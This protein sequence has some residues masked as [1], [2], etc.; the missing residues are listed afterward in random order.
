[1]MPLQLNDLSPTRF[2]DLLRQRCGANG[3]E[4]GKLFAAVHGPKARQHLAEMADVAAVRRTVLDQ[5]LATGEWPRLKKV[6]TETSPFDGFTRYLFEC[7]DGARIEAVR[8]P[9]PCLARGAPIPERLAKKPHYIVCLSS[10]VGCALGCTFCAT[11]RMGFQRNL[12]V[13]EMVEQ[14]R[15]IREEAD[16]PVRGA[17]FMGMGEPLLN[18]D[19]VMEVA[20]ILSAPAGYALSADRITI[21]T[22]GVVPAIRR[23]TAER[24]PY[25]LAIS[26]TAATTAKR[27]QVMPIEKVWPLP[28]LMA[29][30][31]EHQASR[32]DR[33]MIAWVA[34]DGFNVAEEDVRELAELC[35]GLPLRLDLIEVADPQGHFVPPSAEKLSS[36]REGLKILGQPV[37]RRYSGGRDVNAG[38]GMLAATALDG[39]MKKAA[40]AAPGRLSINDFEG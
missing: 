19:R 23:Y 36:F 27:R 34:I 38:C 13:F 32:G 12:S 33:A 20:Q 39:G 8:I 5:V 6:G 29:A 26:L 10:Q 22:A 24:R 4:T 14:V 11:G 21:S 28:E 30:V 18:Y 25:R 37:V 3:A 35:R 9:M 40:P 7:A 17:V 31:R 16:L 1:M 2:N 15:W